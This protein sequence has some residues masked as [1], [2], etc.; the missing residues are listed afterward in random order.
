MPDGSTTYHISCFVCYSFTP[1]NHQLR[2]VRTHQKLQSELQMA[3]IPNKRLLQLIC[4]LLHNT[5]RLLHYCLRPKAPQY[6]FDGS[7]CSAHPP[8]AHPHQALHQHTAPATLVHTHLSICTMAQP[9]ERIHYLLLALI[10]QPSPQKPTAMLIQ[11][12][13]HL[14]ILKLYMAATYCCRLLTPTNENA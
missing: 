5:N 3:A 14:S 11:Q 8:A 9:A 12:Q 10:Y 2:L 1:I 13:T 4:T 7:A 6:L